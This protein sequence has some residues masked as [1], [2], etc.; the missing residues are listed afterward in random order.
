MI[1]VKKNA[2]GIAPNFQQF[3]EDE[4]SGKKYAKTFL[5]RKD[6]FKSMYVVNKVDIKNYYQFFLNTNLPSDA[7]M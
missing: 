3:P 1:M 2:W 6:F 7:V 4:K 5:R